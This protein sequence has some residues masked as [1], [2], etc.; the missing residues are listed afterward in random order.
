MPDDDE[1]LPSLLRAA[2]PVGRVDVTVE[3]ARELNV[4]P[5]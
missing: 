4:E 3:E 5:D 1:E 2:V